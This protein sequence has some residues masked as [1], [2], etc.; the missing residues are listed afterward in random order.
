MPD[1]AGHY[2]KWLLF[3]PNIDIAL[4]FCKCFLGGVESPLFFRV[5]PEAKLVQLAKNGDLSGYLDGV[6]F[7]ATKGRVRRLKPL[8]L[9]V[10]LDRKDDAARL[11]KEP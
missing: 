8:L 3:P 4:S 11:R 2:A 5:A 10:A 7:D 1:A 9:A 6:G